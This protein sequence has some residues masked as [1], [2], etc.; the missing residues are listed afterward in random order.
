MSAKRPGQ[1]PMID[2]A[3]GE[4]Q[5]SEIPF[6]VQA[7]RI[8]AARA[9][10]GADIDAL[11]KLSPPVLA[12]SWIR[13]HPNEAELERALVVAARQES[14]GPLRWLLESAARH[15]VDTAAITAQLTDGVPGETP[16]M[17]A[18]RSGDQEVL[19][20]LLP[21]SDALAVDG[22]GRTALMI[23]AGSAKCEAMLKLLPASDAK[24]RD[25]RGNT[26][27]ILAASHPSTTPEALRALL[28]E[29]DAKAVN[30]A[31]ANAMM[32]AVEWHWGHAEIL[33]MLASRSDLSA[34]SITGQTVY[35]LVA[36]SVIMRGAWAALD[37][38]AESG[39]RA[40]VDGFFKIGGAQLMPR[41]AARME[42]EALAVEMLREDGGCAGQKGNAEK[43]EIGA[44]QGTALRRL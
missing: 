24:A 18:A 15:G 11:K 10:Y 23:A 31:G 36:E 38:V 9:I 40:A 20:A 41:W 26:A 2:N 12:D 27:L 43:R 7:W 14:L 17:E 29:S 37:L 39:P 35:D 30:K 21:F 33:E 22:M 28:A 32:M 5:G 25:S 3:P 4:S 6:R 1:E 34:K 19:E 8:D 13:V 16:L 44:N 42:A